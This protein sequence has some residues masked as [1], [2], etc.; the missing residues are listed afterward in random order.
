MFE[1]KDVINQ[2]L[3]LVRSDSL[4]LSK[5]F[6]L[7]NNKHFEET[8]TGRD[9]VSKEKPILHIASPVKIE[10]ALDKT[11]SLDVD[12]SDYGSV[13]FDSV[14]P[15]APTPFV[16]VDEYM[17][18]E[19]NGL[20][21]H[22]RAFSDPETAIKQDD[23][24][25]LRKHP[26]GV[27]LQQLKVER[28]LGCLDHSYEIKGT[29][30]KMSNL[31]SFFE[32]SSNDNS[33]AHSCHQTDNIAEPQAVGCELC[34]DG[35]HNSQHDAH[36]CLTANTPLDNDQYTDMS[37]AAQ[38]SVGASHRDHEGHSKRKMFTSNTKMKIEGSHVGFDVAVE[39]SLSE[40]EDDTESDNSLPQISMS[41]PRILRNRKYASRA[42]R[43]YST[44]L[45]DSAD[46]NLAFQCEHKVTFNDLVHVAI[47]FIDV[48]FWICVGIGL[49][50]Y[51]YRSQ[52]GACQESLS[53]NNGTPRL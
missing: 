10:A 44:S 35:H 14:E 21:C 23:K 46:R 27:S 47:S 45:I 29:S 31:I 12:N 28:S 32:N 24:W 34:P 33:D 16:F 49:I 18:G 3:C 22:M 13:C 38:L 8:H 11:V 7:L 51:E 20:K 30:P 2:I 48:A 6:F 52:T 39:R 15:S 5:M 4:Y 40:F 41:F 37:N 26:L 50:I 1:K 43:E 25:T 9:V 17:V 36:D 53:G 42:A 19:H